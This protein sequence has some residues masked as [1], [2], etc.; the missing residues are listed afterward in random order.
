MY[1]IRSDLSLLPHGAVPKELSGYSPV[2][3]SGLSTNQFP[4]NI[5]R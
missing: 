5:I 2:F 3:F 1:E 4:S